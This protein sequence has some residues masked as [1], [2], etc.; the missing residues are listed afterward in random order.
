MKHMPLVYWGEHGGGLVEELS[1]GWSGGYSDGDL[2]KGCWMFWSAY[3]CGTK[4]LREYL[5]N[6]S[7]AFIYTTAMPPALAQATCKT[8]LQIIQ[9]RKII[10]A[11]ICMRTRSIRVQGFR[12]W[13]LI[14]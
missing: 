3:A 13:D 14:Q 2:V 1:V 10:C 4:I 11:V 12:E 9:R 6:K 8:A 7:R 5:I